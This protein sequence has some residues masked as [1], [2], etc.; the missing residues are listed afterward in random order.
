MDM[1]RDYFTRENLV[2]SVTKAPYVPGRLG[3]LGIFET[4]GLTSTTL[5]AEELGLNDVGPGSAIPRGAPPQA[6]TLDKRKVH[7]FSTSTYAKTL[8]VFADEVLGMRASGTTG[9]AEVITTRRNEAVAKLR[10]WADAQHEYLRMTTLLSPNN[11]FGN[12][13][14]DG[15]IALAT[16]A[17]KTRQEIFNKVI[18][19]IETALKGLSFSGVH[20]L[21]SDT[22]WA[23]LI[24]N[25]AIKDTYLNTQAAGELRNDPRDMFVY[26]GVMWERYRG[27]ATIAI[28]ND[29]AVVIP[30]GVSGLFLQGF[31]P[32]DTIDSVGAGA[33]GAPYYPRAE[34][35]KGG[36]GWE[37][38]MQ[39]HPVMLCTR[40]EAIIT[41][42]KS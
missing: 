21:C 20:C 33:M 40:P 14:A 1:Y 38:T 42:A 25:K 4:R 23:D 37:I 17:T 10:M 16:D 11:A 3:E 34:A 27:S 30:L 35:M 24:E 18:K 7:T 8:P 15:S 28:T 9:A 32:D 6:M 41:L 5:A 39:T 2:E 29:K 26:G 36:K 13:P 31:A 12:K 22:F 19:P